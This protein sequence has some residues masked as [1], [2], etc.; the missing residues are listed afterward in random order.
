MTILVDTTNIHEIPVLTL[1]PGEADR[2]P[3]IF[4]V[5]GFGGSKETGLSLGHQ[6]AQ[7]GFCFVSFDAWLHGERYD[8]LLEQAA[9]PKRGRIYP[10]DSGL[11]RFVLFYRVIE[12][13]RADV[14]TLIEHF[15]DD[16]RMVALEAYIHWERRG[17]KLEPGKH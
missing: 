6:L 7:H 5:H 8:M 14:Q 1:T 15:A 10:P 11:D 4:F 13:C 12:R 2:C 17:V 16:P 3:L 9:L